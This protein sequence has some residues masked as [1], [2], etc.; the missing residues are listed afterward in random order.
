MNTY[1]EINGDWKAYLKRFQMPCKS[2]L[3][4]P[5]FRMTICFLLQLPIVFICWYYKEVGFP[6][7]F[8]AMVTILGILSY[9]IKI[10]Y[11]EFWNY[12]LVESLGF[13]ADLLMWLYYFILTVLSLLPI[14]VFFVMFELK[15]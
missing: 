5:L 4:L 13:F 3:R 11:K 14:I 12:V 8:L 2:T 10:L 15:C 1:N 6:I 7:I 9:Y